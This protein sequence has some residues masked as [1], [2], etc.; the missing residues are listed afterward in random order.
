MKQVMRKQVMR[1]TG[2]GVVR[3]PIAVSC[4]ELMEV[5]ITDLQRKN[6]RGRDREKKKQRERERNTESC[7]IHR[8]PRYTKVGGRQ[9]ERREGESE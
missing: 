8:D 2:Y 3:N 7:R 1:Q 6:E 9:R 4:R 5:E